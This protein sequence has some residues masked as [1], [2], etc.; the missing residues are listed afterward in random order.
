MRQAGRLQELYEK[1]SGNADFWW[2]YIQEA[3]ASDGRRPSRTVKIP[4]HKTFQDR[5]KAATGC[6]ASSSL[7]VPVLLDD[8]NDSASKAYSALPERFFIL[9]T[10]GKVAYAGKRG[11]HGVDLTALEKRLKELTSGGKE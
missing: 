2:I 11:P 5:E 1:Y 4:L 6:S 9:G 8:M 3:H 7:K 10:D